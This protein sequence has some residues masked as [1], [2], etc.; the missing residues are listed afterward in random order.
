MIRQREVERLERMV[1]Q[2]RQS[3]AKVRTFGTAPETG[4][5]APAALVEEPADDI[6]A[7]S[8]EIFGPVLS[9]RRFT[10]HD[11]VVA[12]VNAWRTGLGGYVATAGP[13]RQVALA[14]ALDVGL[15]AVNNGAPNTPEVPF[16]GRGDSGLGREGGMSGLLEFTCE[17]T[18]SIAR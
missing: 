3:G 18:I 5:Y 10:D 13:E 7:W 15:V 6:D 1:D 11:Q 4:W 9:V 8:T 12:E 17:Q 14:R 16:G 2:A